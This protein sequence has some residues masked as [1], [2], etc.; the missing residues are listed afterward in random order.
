MTRH[1]SAD[2]PANKRLQMKKLF[3]GMYMD[4]RNGFMITREAVF[5]PRVGRKWIAEW[6]SSSHGMFMPSSFSK[7]FSTFAEARAH[8]QSILDTSR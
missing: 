4:R 7:E 1:R 5:D 6:K 8:L 3:A 2:R